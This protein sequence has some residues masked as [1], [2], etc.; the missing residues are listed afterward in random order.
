MNNIPKI[1]IIIPIYNMEKY[2]HKCLDSVLSQTIGSKEIICIDDGSTDG[3]LNIII[4]YAKKYPEI[5]II[6]QTRRGSGSARNAGLKRATGNYIAF[7]DAD[8]YYAS[9]DVLD[10]LYNGVIENDTK[11]AGGRMI[12]LMEGRLIKSGMKCIDRTNFTNDGIISYTDYQQFYGYQ[13]FI[14]NRK[15]LIDNNIEFPDY[16]RMQDPIFMIEA[17]QLAEKIWVTNKEIYIY[18][19]TDKLIDYYSSKVIN[20]IADVLLDILQFSKKNNLNE[21]PAEVLET[22][23][24]CKEYFF[25]MIYR[26]DKNL[27]SKLKELDGYFEDSDKNGDEYFL[28]ATREEIEAYINQSNAK[29]HELIDVIKKYDGLIIYGA[30]GYGKRVYEIIK[31]FDDIDFKG[32]AVT[33]IA[34]KNEYVQGEP[35]RQI[36]DYIDLKEKALV[37]VAGKGDKANAMEATAVE[38]GFRNIIVVSEKVI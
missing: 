36:D 38:K 26:G 7:M 16:N 29:A 37:I 5:I 21:I 11:A 18:R 28:G 3:S 19:Q 2:L 24:G 34:S 20:G 6:R 17:L 13:A 27:H 23:R 1:S 15:M 8:D 30:G 10:Y 35:V 31:G 22:I 32:F 12:A 9:A 4:D 33:T 14:Y 25:Y